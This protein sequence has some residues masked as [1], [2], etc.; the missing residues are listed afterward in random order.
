MSEITLYS[1]DNCGKE[2][3]HKSRFEVIVDRIVDPTTGTETIR[4]YL[5]L[6]ETCQSHALDIIIQTLS[7]ND[8]KLFYKKYSKNKKEL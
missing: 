5:D 2:F 7:I 3:K 4:E 1:C 6:C 8:S